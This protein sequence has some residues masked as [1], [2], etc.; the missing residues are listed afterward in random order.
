MTIDD[1]V[2]ARAQI[3]VVQ[4][5]VQGFMEDQRDKIGSALQRWESISLEDLDGELLEQVKTTRS[6]LRAAYRQL[7]GQQ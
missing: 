4:N 1:C 3:L 7:G 2:T 5:D 6:E